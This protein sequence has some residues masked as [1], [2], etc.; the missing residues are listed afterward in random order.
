MEHRSFIFLTHLIDWVII[1][2]ILLEPVG[3][4]FMVGWLAGIRWYFVANKCWLSMYGGFPLA[5]SIGDRPMKI[6]F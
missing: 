5:F 1:M 4:Y 2:S 3:C 6:A